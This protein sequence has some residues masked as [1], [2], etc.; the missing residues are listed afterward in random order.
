MVDC[1]DIK[2]NEGIPVKDIQISSVEPNTEDTVEVKVEQ[3]QELE[4]EDLESD[5]ESVNIQADSRQQT[6]TKP[7]SIIVQKNHLDKSN[8]W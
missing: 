6:E 5:D 1:I 2:I 4:K 7:P 3:V 8:N